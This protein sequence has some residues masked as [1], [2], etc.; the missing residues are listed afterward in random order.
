MNP[1]QMLGSVMKSGGN[2]QKIIMQMMRQNMDS[3]PMMQN[4]YNMAQNGDAKGIEQFA[5]NL[6]KEKGINADEMFGT[7]KQQMGL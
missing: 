6:C 1:M 5:R 3:N 7:I 4:V 2:P